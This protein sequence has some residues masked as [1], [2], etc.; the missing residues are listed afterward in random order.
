MREGDIEKQDKVT[1][2]SPVSNSLILEES[3]KSDEFQNNILVNEM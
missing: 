1:P 3:L 2:V